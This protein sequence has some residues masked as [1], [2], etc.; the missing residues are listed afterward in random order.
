MILL[1]LK[2]YIEERQSASVS[3]LARHFALSEDGVRAM[4]QVWEERGGL[5]VEYDSDGRVTRYRFVGAEEIPVAML[6]DR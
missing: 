3:E 4:M 2:A 5:S 1:A 6:S